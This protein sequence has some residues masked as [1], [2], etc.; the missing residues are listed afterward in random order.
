MLHWIK[1]NIEKIIIGVT[2][3]LMFLAMVF[4]SK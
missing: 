1:E 2:L 4:L 3:L